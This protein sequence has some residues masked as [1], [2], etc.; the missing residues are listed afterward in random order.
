PRSSSHGVEFVEGLVRN[1]S[2]GDSSREL[3]AWLPAVLGP[4]TPPDSQESLRPFGHFPH[5]RRC[6]GDG[7]LRGGSPGLAEP[8][9]PHQASTSSPHGVETLAAKAMTAAWIG[10]AKCAHVAT[11]QPKSGS[12]TTPAGHPRGTH[13]GL[14][15][16]QGI[17]THSTTALNC[18]RST[19]KVR[20]DSLRRLSRA[21]PIC[22]LQ[23]GGSHFI[24]MGIPLSWI[25]RPFMKDF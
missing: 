14:D 15:C 16:R 9:V 19:P 1:I 13:C 3:C 2:R 7:W 18:K 20:L 22:S 24:F 23:T 21:G 4:D 6:R 11:T 8:G 25:A 17:S 12:S 10:P 5:L